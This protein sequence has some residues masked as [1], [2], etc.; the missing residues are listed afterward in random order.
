M[1]TKE[2]N[3]I[4]TA[5]ETIERRAAFSAEMAEAMKKTD[6]GAYWQAKAEAYREAADLVGAWC[7]VRA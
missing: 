7:G 5:L 4:R 2:R 1:T 3:D 6:T